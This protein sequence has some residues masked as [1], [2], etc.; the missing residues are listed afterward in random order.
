MG[1]FN[2]V[3]RPDRTLE[4]WAAMQGDQQAWP[5]RIVIAVLDGCEV[6]HLNRHL[7][8]PNPGTASVT[9]V[10]VVAV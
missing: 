5:D 3:G 7:P 9:V 2:R 1:A 6:L 10:V 8:I 4:M